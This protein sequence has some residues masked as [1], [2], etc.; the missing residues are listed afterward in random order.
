V[1]EGGRP[2]LLLSERLKLGWEWSCRLIFPGSRSAPLRTSKGY[3]AVIDPPSF[4]LASPYFHD[5]HKC[6]KDPSLTCFAFNLNPNLLLL[7]HHATAHVKHP[8]FAHLVSPR[9]HPHI[10]CSLHYLT[11]TRHPL[12]GVLASVFSRQIK[13]LNS[14]I[15]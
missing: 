12:V 14:H 3:E 9:P 6:L 2:R 8:R 13:I 4:H 1:C 5:L 10:M 7:A 11:S 15:I